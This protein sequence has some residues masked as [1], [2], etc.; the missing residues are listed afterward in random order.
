M[1]ID[2]GS[3]RKTSNN[4]KTIMKIN[5]SILALG[6]LAL[7]TVVPTTVYGEEKEETVS[8][9]KVPAAVHQT[10]STYAKDSEVTKIEKGNE[11]GKKMYEFAITQG[12]HSFEVSISKKGKYLGQEE[13]IQLT[14]VP[15]AVQTALKAKAGSGTLSGFEKTTDKDQTVTY[16]A[17]IANGGKKTE[18]TVDASGKIIGIEDASSDKD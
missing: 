11:D 13:D 6:A 2:R 15:E 18:V 5:Y 7:A 1:H 17:D 14:D 3:G 9:D 12:A 8:M 4:K 10:L 16:E